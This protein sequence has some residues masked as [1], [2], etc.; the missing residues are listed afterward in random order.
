MTH[1][2]QAEKQK[3]SSKVWQ[4]RG[5]GRGYGFVTRKVTKYLCRHRVKTIPQ[6]SDVSTE[7]GSVI[8]TTNKSPNLS[9]PGR[10]DAN[11]L[12][13]FMGASSGDF[14]SETYVDLGGLSQREEKMWSATGD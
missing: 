13:G 6:L 5:G 14:E 2:D 4:D 12:T 11:N 9:E 1:L 8:T 7:R 3:I 10:K